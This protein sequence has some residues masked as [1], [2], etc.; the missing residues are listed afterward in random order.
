MMARIERY[1][2]KRSEYGG[3]DGQPQRDPSGGSLPLADLA[4]SSRVSER[5]RL[6]RSAGIN[7]F[8]P[9]RSDLVGLAA[10]GLNPNEM[11]AAEFA[12]YEKD[13]ALSN[14]RAAEREKLSDASNDYINEPEQYVGESGEGNGVEAF[15]DGA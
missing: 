2:G 5:A 14:L 13:L 9:A 10:T 8:D 4:S 12:Q 1:P 7:D 15:G 3:G 6:M 11:N